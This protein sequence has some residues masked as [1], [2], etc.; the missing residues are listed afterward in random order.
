M[1]CTLSLSLLH[2]VSD[3]SQ[4]LNNCCLNPFF[5]SSPEVLNADS[6]SFIR[7]RFRICTDLSAAPFDAG[8]YAGS[9]VCLIPFLSRNWVNSLETSYGPL[10]DTSSS[11]RPYEA[12]R[13]CSTSMVLWEVVEGMG[14]TSN[15]FEW[16]SMTTKKYCL[17]FSAKSMWILCHTLSGH[18]Q[19]C[20][21]ATAGIFCIAWQTGQLCTSSWI[22]SSQPGHQR[23][24]RVRAFMR[25]I[26][27]CSW[28]RS[29]NLCR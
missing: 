27:G 1:Y 8:W 22:S 26:P 12:N 11:G 14:K 6:T 20:S 13:P 17:S 18:L 5:Y 7:T 25:Q 23:W 16:L 9:A 28:W 15:H 29:S 21:G 2:K 4:A 19:G 3:S 24:L 10:S